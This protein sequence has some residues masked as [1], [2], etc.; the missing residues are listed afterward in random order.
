[1]LKVDQPQDIVQALAS[2]GEILNRPVQKPFVITGYDKKW[3]LYPGNHI[4]LPAGAYKITLPNFPGVDTTSLRTE[5]L[6]VAPG[7]TTTVNVSVK[8]SKMSVERS[9]SQ[10]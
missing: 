6:E 8:D 9:I 5:D 1:L 4:R 10:N 3:D 2:Y 7:H